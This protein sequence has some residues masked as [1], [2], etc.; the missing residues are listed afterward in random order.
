M[1]HSLPPEI[2]S[3]VYGILSPTPPLPPS[4]HFVPH[5]RQS[6]FENLEITSFNQI[7]RLAAIFNDPRT[8]AG[9]EYV[10][11]VDVGFAMESTEELL[12]KFEGNP[13][14]WSDLLTKFEGLREIKCRDWMSTSLGLLS[15]AQDRA[16]GGGPSSLAKLKKA[17]ISIL[18]TQLNQEDFVLHRLAL[19]NEYK[20]LES[21]EVVVQPFDP[22][23]STTNAFELFPSIPP[24]S[25]ELDGFPSASIHQIK[26]LTLVGPLC[27]RRLQT[28]LASFD[29]VRNLAFFDLFSS[30]QNL[31]PLLS[32]LRSPESLESLKLFQLYSTSLPINL[33]PSRNIS[34]TPFTSLSSLEIN[35]PLPGLTA[36][37]LLLPSL[38]HLTFSTHSTPSFDLIHELIVSK[39]PAL[40]NLT[41][42]HIS[43][44]VGPPLSR[45]TYPQVLSWLSSLLSSTPDSPSSNRFPIDHWQIPV[46]PSEFDPNLTE[47]LFPLA[48]SKGIS[49]EGSQLISAMLTAFVLDKQLESWKELLEN[50]EQDQDGS[51]KEEREEMEA[52]F[53]DSRFW[54]A[55]ALRYSSRL[56]LTVPVNREQEG[57]EAEEQMELI[58]STAAGTEE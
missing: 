53:G 3:N 47:I 4:R 58:G 37:D 13:T 1:L 48:Q 2:L 9:A 54:D 40:S 15:S 36:Q 22:S 51:G 34:F 32:A 6:L 30:S 50:E 38:T 46:W 52:V 11:R 5:F 26:D 49:L 57:G 45:E 55:L 24:S 18:L 31:S 41:L 43:G 44:S 35:V 20:S 19:I 14:I 25:L 16:G 33:P 39:P 56:G 42:S 7:S 12:T 28:V 17:T 27:D 29:N 21:L 10:K 23:S 8:G